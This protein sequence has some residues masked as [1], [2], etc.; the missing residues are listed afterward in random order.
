MRYCYN[1][2]KITSGEPVYC[3][4][5]GRS[6]NVKRCGR[7]HIN[8]RS[9][10]ACSQCGSRDLSTPQP[11]TPFWVPVVEFL[12][13]LIPGVLLGIVS[14]LSV[15]IAIRALLE[16]PDMLCFFA[17]LLIA[18]GILWSVW[19]KLP[20]WLRTAVYR[21]LKRKRDGQDRTGGH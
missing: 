12:V 2:N 14:I 15:L 13:S 8:P 5:C 9:A 16:R 6:Y 18:L 1:C 20:S 17:M 19:A 11:K 21:M 10:E 7:G 3:N 4:F